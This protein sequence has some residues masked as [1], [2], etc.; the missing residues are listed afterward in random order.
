VN[1]NGPINKPLWLAFTMYC[2]PVN[3]AGCCHS[4]GNSIGMLPLQYEAVAE[5]DAEIALLDVTANELV[6]AQEDEIAIDAVLAFTDHDAV[7][8]FITPAD[9]ETLFKYASEPDTMT[10]RQ[11]GILFPF[12]C[13]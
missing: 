9:V 10:L 3:V 2:E 6:D 12:S 4:S 5:Y 13:G 8:L 1:P 7:K 11:F